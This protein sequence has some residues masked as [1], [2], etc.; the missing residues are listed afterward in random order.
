[1]NKVIYDLQ[2][3]CR[4]KY[5]TSHAS[6]HLTDK[7]KEQ[8]DGGNFACGIFVN[9]QETFDSVDHDIL[10]QKLNCYGIREVPNN[11]FSSYVHNMLQYVSI[12]GFN[13]NLE[14]INFGVPQ[15]SI[16]GPLLL[17]IYINDFNRYCLVHHFAE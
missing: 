13:S 2:F 16:L 5:S 1:M 14:H 7:R 3:G 8:P 9:L 4:Q 6:S 17:L 12:N 10:I 11:W 15:G